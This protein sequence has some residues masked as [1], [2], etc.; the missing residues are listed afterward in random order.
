MLDLSELWSWSPLLLAPLAGWSLFRLAK[1]IHYRWLRIP[2]RTL[3]WLFIAGSSLLVGLFVLVQLG[4]TRHARIW[5]PDGTHAVV[6][7]FIGQ[8]ALGAD[9]ANLSIRHGW[10]PFAN[11][12]YQ[13][14]AQWDFKNGKLVSPECRWL[15]NT[16]LVI[17]NFNESARC[18]THAGNIAVFCDD[19]SAAPKR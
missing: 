16:H 2:A 9:F 11:R 19:A 3:A 10:S 5:S 18:E 6:I 14:E 4:C 17:R 7:S 13:G 1:Y 12:I 15:D 8:G